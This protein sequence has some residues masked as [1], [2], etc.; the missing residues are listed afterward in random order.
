MSKGYLFLNGDPPSKKLLDS[1][2][3]EDKLIICTDGAYDYLKDIIRPD[4]IVGDLDSIKSDITGECEILKLPQEKDY[5]DGHIALLTMIER[6]I[7]EVT[8]FGALGGRPD[9]NLSN[10]GLLALA[11]NFQVSACFETDDFYVF[12]AE[13]NFKKPAIIGKTVS[14]L[15]YTDFVH[16]ISTEGL[17]YGI[18]NKTLD[19]VHILGIS[20]VA[21]DKNISYKITSGTALVFLEK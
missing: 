9:H 20:N 21:T 11:R 16:I 15:P 7:N 18:D 13:G 19:K 6:G 8:I 17:K 3:I 5:T 1:L 10:Y 2:N 4:V 12:M 14:L